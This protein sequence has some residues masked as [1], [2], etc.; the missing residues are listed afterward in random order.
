MGFWKDRKDKNKNRVIFD[1]VKIVE[2]GKTYSVKSS[3]P[4]I[5]FIDI[6]ENS[7]ASPRSLI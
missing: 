4:Y 7:Y 3:I 1:T 2:N 6:T 5:I